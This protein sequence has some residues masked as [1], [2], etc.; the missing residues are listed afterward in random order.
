M[1]HLSC[2]VMTQQRHRNLENERT[3]RPANTVR[4]VI[5]QSGIDRMTFTDGYGN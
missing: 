3:R 2:G 4:G 1:K 5:D